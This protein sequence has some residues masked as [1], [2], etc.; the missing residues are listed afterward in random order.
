M[1]RL[2]VRVLVG[3]ALVGSG[4][5]QGS[6]HSSY[7]SD[8]CVRVQ[9]FSAYCGRVNPAAR[10][11]VD[12]FARLIGA[13]EYIN[14]PGLASFLERH[15]PIAIA[16]FIARQ[17]QGLWLWLRLLAA[18][19]NHHSDHMLTHSLIVA[20]IRAR[21]AADRRVILFPP[22]LVFSAQKTKS[23]IH[24]LSVQFPRLGGTTRLV[25]PDKDHA[26]VHAYTIA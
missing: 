2:V 4:I 5:H 22:G 1:R 20:M 11:S 15:N 6:L 3:I 17:G 13:E 24:P 25:V 21:A 9:A 8:Y 23:A 19:L 10:V 14:S 12:V 18:V 16:C 26:L 7:L